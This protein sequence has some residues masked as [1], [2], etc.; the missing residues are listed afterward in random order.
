MVVFWKIASLNN[1]HEGMGDHAFGMS[2]GGQ[3]RSAV[4]AGAQALR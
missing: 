4:R 2:T 1:L 3:R